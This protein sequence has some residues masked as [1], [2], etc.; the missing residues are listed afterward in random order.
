MTDMQTSNDADAIVRVS[1]NN[2]AGRARE[3]ETQLAQGD[4]RRAR[5]GAHWFGPGG[6][7][8]VTRYG[9]IAV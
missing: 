4:G 3:L 5:R 2:S 8:G 7:A 9:N 6:I 1:C